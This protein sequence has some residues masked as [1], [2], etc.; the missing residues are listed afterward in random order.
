MVIK[1]DNMSA[2]AM[3]ARMRIKAS[4]LVAREIALLFCESAFEAKMFEHIPG[5]TNLLADE[6]SRASELG[7]PSQLPA[8]LI[9]VHRTLVPQRSRDFYRTLATE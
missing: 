7:R 4:P 2:L 3:G 6:L 1:S 9:G 8:Q 5:L